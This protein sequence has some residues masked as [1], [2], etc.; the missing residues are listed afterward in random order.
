MAAFFDVTPSALRKTYSRIMRKGKERGKIRL[1]KIQWNLA[2][3]SAAMAIFLG[4][5][6]LEQSDHNEGNL[7]VDAEQISRVFAKMVSAAGT[8]KATPDNQPISE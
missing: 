1:R 6:Y 2:E 4:K 3:K 8:G 7:N 5:N